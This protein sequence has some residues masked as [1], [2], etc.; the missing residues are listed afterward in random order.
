MC[1]RP[2]PRATLVPMRSTDSVR[3]WLILTQERLVKPAALL[4]RVSGKPA[5]G[6]WLVKAKAITVPDRSLKTS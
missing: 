1:A 6:S 3:I 4:S 2:Q 5:R